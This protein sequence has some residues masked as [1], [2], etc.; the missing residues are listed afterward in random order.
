MALITASIAERERFTA[1]AG[2]NDASAPLDSMA[3][4]RFLETFNP[5]C[6]T[7]DGI[8]PGSL[9]EDVEGTL[10]A[11]TRITLSEIESREYIEFERQPEGLLFRLDYTGRFADGARETKEYDPGAKIFSIGVVRQH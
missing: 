7:V 9:V 4:I 1:F 5:T 2:E 10:A 11:T 6:T 3:T 8:G